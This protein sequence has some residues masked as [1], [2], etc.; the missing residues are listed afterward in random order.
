MKIRKKRVYEYSEASDGCRILVD[1]IWPRGV[2]KADA[3]LNLW[4]KVVAP[5]SELRKWFGHDPAKFPLFR[6][7]YWEELETDSEKQEGLRTIQSKAQEGPVTLVY[8]AKDEVY[9]HVVV[10]EAFLKT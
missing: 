5:S 8:A 7:K 1:R 2:K 9:N 10:L 3:D 4:L 6:Q